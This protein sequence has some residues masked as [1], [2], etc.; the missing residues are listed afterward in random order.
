M[1]D[2]LQVLF[3]LMVTTPLISAMARSPSFE[4]GLNFLKYLKSDV[5]LDVVVKNQAIFFNAQ[6]SLL[7]KQQILYQV[8]ELS[9]MRF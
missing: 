1:A 4:S 8:K 3:F 9:G 5:I 2:G 7:F 6:V